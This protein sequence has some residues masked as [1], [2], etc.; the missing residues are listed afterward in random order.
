M[1]TLA[2]GIAGGLLINRVGH[3]NSQTSE[4]AT[5]SVR[6]ALAVVFCNRYAVLAINIVSMMIVARLVTPA[7]TGLFSVAA[8]I[9]L[10]AQAI[11][12]FGIAEFLVQEKELT[13]AKIRTAFGLNLLL[14]WS[15]GGI[16]FLS[17]GWIADLYKTP[18]L[19][20]LIAIVCGSF[21][22]AP[23]SSTVLALLNRRMDFRA[24]FKV[25]ILSNLANSMVSISLAYLGWGAM[26]LSLGMLAMNVTTAVI[27][28]LFLRSWDH[29]IPSLREWRRLGS[30][31]LYMSSA[32]IVSQVGSRVPELI[33]GRL[34]GFEPLGQFN[35]ARGVVFLFYE[36]LVS[37]VNTVAFPAF[38]AAHHAGEN[39]RVSYLRATTLITG[40]ILPVMAVLSI[41]SEPLVRF[42][43]GDQWLPAARLMPI[44]VVGAAIG[45][46]APIVSQ[47]L[48]ATGG[49]RLLL[50]SAIY[51]QAC[52]L[53][54]V[55]IFANFGLTWLAISQA[56][57]GVTS[58]AINAYVLRRGIGVRLP[59]LLRASV[60][61]LWLALI[62]VV[63]PLA[64]VTWRGPFGDP[65]L[66]TLLASAS[67]A[68]VSWV[69]GVFMIR[70]PLSGEIQMVMREARRMVR[71]K[72]SA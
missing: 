34:L 64:Y 53:I 42:I 8:S 57:S 40:L 1:R 26:A 56:I 60:P 62:S 13:Q 5:M 37:S 71:R 45:S 65:A 10:L 12:D 36:L 39:V 30:F 17:R 54:L 18:E 35:R 59:E 67:L 6:G 47:V 55:G 61:S 20:N 24:L 51:S 21:L 25:S 14:A 31:G 28:G 16:I 33:I 58:F 23:F 70:H 2:Y 43:L 49:I 72:T 15:L 11:R 41:T 4:N 7:E 69:S 3:L 66:L 27:T 44:L 52:G 29:F 48:S 19:T 68:S 9:V 50:H 38:S 63:P 46:L 22:V 32:N